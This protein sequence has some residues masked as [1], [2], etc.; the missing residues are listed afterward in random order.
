VEPPAG[1][2][3]APPAMRR[4]ADELSEAWV[5]AYDRDAAAV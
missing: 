4:Q 2:A 5:A 1:R 3:A